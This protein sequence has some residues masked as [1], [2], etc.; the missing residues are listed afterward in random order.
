MKR[1]AGHRDA[2][3]AGAFRP[4]STRAHA[5]RTIVMALGAG[6]VKVGIARSLA[7]P[8]GNVTGVTTMRDELTSKQIELLKT[9]APGISRL[10]VLTPGKALVHDE[11]WRDATRAAQALKLKQ[12]RRNF[13]VVSFPFVRLEKLPYLSRKEKPAEARLHAGFEAITSAISTP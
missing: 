11:T 13:S 4:R 9:I 12:G 3:R 1:N 5:H 8:G 10:G 6:A 7:C 2:G